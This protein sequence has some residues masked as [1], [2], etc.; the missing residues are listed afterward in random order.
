[1]HRAAYA[2]AAVLFNPLPPHLRFPAKFDCL[3][4]P[5]SGVS[6]L[7]PGLLLPQNPDDLLFREPAC[8]HPP[9]GDGL[10]PF[11]EDLRG[12]GQGHQATR[13][14]VLGGLERR[15]WSQDDKAR[16]VRRDRHTYHKRQEKVP[17]KRR[18][19]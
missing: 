4:P 2:A 5:F 19:L 7:R 12:S 17:S 15:R 1:M 13:V 11:L 8:L 10:Y 6:R 3:N 14:E 9:V 18:L 16:I